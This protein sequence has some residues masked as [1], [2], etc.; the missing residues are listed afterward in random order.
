MTTIHVLEAVDSTNDIALAAAEAGD[1]HGSCWIADHQRS[2]RGRR[3]VGGQQRSWHSPSGKNLYLSLLL[4]PNLAPNIAAPLT[5]AAAL[6]VRRALVQTSPALDEDLWIKWPN[7][8]YHGDRKLGGILTEGVMT[9]A[10]L[11][12]VI[13]GIGLNI[14]IAAS[15]FPEEITEIATST[16]AA[17]GEPIDRLAL[18]LEVRREVLI[19]SQIL[20]E[21][22]LEAIL[23]ELRAHDRSKG[24]TVFA[25]RG[26]DEIEGVSQGIDD[27]GHLRVELE[28]GSILS[29]QAGEVRFA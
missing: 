2:G 12:A 14:N 21:D 22:G 6:G 15:D 16:L 4:R 1:A 7:D 13:V 11:D 18:A 26:E 28:D 19:A 10:K 25:T 8:L 23:D 17:T 9:G 20:I 3:E 29:V 27:K 5:L 24:R